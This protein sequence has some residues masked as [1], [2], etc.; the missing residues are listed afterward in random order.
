MPAFGGSLCQR[1]AATPQAPALEIP[2]RRQSEK[3]ERAQS[4]AG[5]KQSGF[6]KDKRGIAAG[7]NGGG[8]NWL[9]SGLCTSTAQQPI[10]PAR[11][12]NVNLVL[13]T[14]RAAKKAVGKAAKTAVRKVSEKRK[15]RSGAVAPRRP[16]LSIYL[17]RVFCDNAT[18][19][20]RR[21]FQG[22]KVH[23]PSLWL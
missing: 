1:G 6:G 19:R 5:W 16:R 3:A 15:G 23:M 21:L 4:V 8:R 17:T 11:N 22:R 2:E 10:R 7:A 14:V 12:A 13:S 18:I 20:Q 9:S